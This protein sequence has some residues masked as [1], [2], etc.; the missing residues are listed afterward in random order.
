MTFYTRDQEETEKWV[1]TFVEGF[2]IEKS[3]L[4]PRS[5]LYKDHFFNFTLH[6]NITMT[7]SARDEQTSATTHFELYSP[8]LISNVLCTD[9]DGNPL[10]V[11]IQM[12]KCLREKAEEQYDQDSYDLGELFYDA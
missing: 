6:L 11:S 7:L 12:L 9:C 1:T 4:S 10:G 5:R 8:S 2:Q 3:N